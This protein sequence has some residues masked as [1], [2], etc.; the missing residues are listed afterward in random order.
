M[1]KHIQVLGIL[2][3]VWGS[4]GLIAALII[5]LVFGGVVGIIGMVS[6]HEQDAAIAIPV[7]SIVGGAIFF[8]LLITSLPAIITGIGLLRMASWSRIVGIIV[9]VFH[10][11]S[12]PFGTALGIYGLWVLLSRETLLCFEPPQQPIKI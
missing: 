4:F 9:S 5:M 3:I 12:I 11:F 1:T 8:I 6:G 2:N 7:V 10:L